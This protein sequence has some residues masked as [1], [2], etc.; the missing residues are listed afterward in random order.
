ML[1]RN[2]IFGHVDCTR[3]P[4][5]QIRK[6]RPHAT[7]PLSCTTRFAL[8]FLHSSTNDLLWPSLR[9]GH[10]TEPEESE[11]N[12]ELC[13]FKKHQRNSER[14]AELCSF[15]KHHRNIRILLLNRRKWKIIPKRVPSCMRQTKNVTGLVML[16]SLTMTSRTCACRRFARWRALGGPTRTVQ[17]SSL[18]LCGVSILN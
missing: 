8:M 18:M 3:P 10:Q 5:R 13:S 4:S 15:K 11:R 9:R 12:A 7:A 2:L 14:N 6:A 16:W 17:E 1:F